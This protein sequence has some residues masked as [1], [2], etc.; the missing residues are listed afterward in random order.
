MKPPG[1]TRLALLAIGIVLA[2]VIPLILYGCFYPNLPLPGAIAA[3][4]GPFREM[5]LLE[6]SL[7]VITA[8]GVKPAYMILSLALIIVLGR[9]KSMDLTAL[10]WGLVWF[11]A[12]EI[13]CAVNYLCCGPGSD[14]IEYLHSYGMTVGFSFTAFALLEGLDQRMIKFSSEGERCAGLS[15]CGACIKHTEAPCGLKRLFTAIIP[16]F[17]VLAFIPLCAGWQVISYPSRIFGS[18]YDYSHPVV[19]QMYEIRYCPL[20]AILLFGASWLVL[21][22]KRPDAVPLSK[23]LFAAGLGPLGFGMLRLFLVA[24]YHDNLVWFGVWEEVTELL[25]VASVMVVLWVFRHRLLAPLNAISSPP[26]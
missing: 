2:G 16:A 25:F 12:G 20:L 9:Q 21:I 17:L 26:S 10:R 24:A 13:A 15:L 3:S 14:L 11:L 22:S 18:V 6:Q 7:A 23:I 8:F 1:K 4:P 5:N 19:Y